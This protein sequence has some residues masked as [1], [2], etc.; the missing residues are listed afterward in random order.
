MPLQRRLFSWFDD[1]VH[2]VTKRLL[3][4]GQHSQADLKLGQ[5]PAQ[6]LLLFIIDLGQALL[7][8]LKTI[9]FRVLDVIVPLDKVL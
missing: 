1:G 3:V 2:L 7:E 8:E 5:L 6:V 9:Q 4:L